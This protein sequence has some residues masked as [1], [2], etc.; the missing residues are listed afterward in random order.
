MNLDEIRVGDRLRWRGERSRT[1]LKLYMSP[2]T[3]T[4]EAITNTGRVR[5]TCMGTRKYAKPGDL[6]RIQSE[7]RER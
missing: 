4:V 5:F 2:Q 3:I 1:G 7:E 6:E